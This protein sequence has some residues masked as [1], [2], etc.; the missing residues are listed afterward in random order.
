MCH[1]F[2]FSLRAQSKGAV[3]VK[4]EGCREEEQPTSQ[5]KGGEHHDTLQKESPGASG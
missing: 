1:C 3:Q 4:A 5:E 2:L